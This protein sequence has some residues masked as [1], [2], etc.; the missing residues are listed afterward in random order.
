MAF[1]K[2]KTNLQLV[3]NKKNGH[4]TGFPCYRINIKKL[5][6]GTNLI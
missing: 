2:S 4:P 6:I 1:L 5:L 3:K